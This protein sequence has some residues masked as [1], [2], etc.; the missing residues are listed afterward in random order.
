MPGEMLSPEQACR[1][2]E[3]LHDQD[4]PNHAADQA[5]AGPV[6]LVVNSGTVAAL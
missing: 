3:S 6:L 2:K 5:W 1:T 4:N